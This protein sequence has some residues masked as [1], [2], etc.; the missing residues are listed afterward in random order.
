MDDRWRE[1]HDQHPNLSTKQVSS[2]SKA[3]I[4]DTK[5]ETSKLNIYEISSLIRNKVY[6]E[7][8]EKM[9]WDEVKEK[10]DKFE[11]KESSDNSNNQNYQL[12]PNV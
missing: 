11:I 7:D 9:I 12:W 2:I 8:L 5:Q 3:P 6:G 4:I 10:L 1:Q